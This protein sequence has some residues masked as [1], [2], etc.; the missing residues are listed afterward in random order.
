MDCNVGQI[1]RKDE[2]YAR[3]W[4]A[5]FPNEP[6]A[7]E[8]ADYALKIRRLRNEHEDRCEQCRNYAD[9]IR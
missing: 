4:V 3:G 7:M 8:M 5:L 6:E 9:A 1:M 2:N